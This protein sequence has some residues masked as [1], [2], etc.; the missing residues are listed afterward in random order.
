MQ[1]LFDGSPLE[2]V[3]RKVLHDVDVRVDGERPWDIQVRDPRFYRRALLEGSLGL[4][5]SYMDGWWDCADLEELI[6]R[7][8]S[9]RVDVK[10]RLA[11]FALKM[12]VLAGLTNPQNRRLFQRV[13]R[14]YNLDNDLF[15]AFLGKYKNYSCAHFDGTDDLDVAQAQKMDLICR[16]LDI[17]PGDRVLDIGGGWGEMA[18]HMATRYGAK[19]TSINI[20]DEQIR[21]A[22]EH[23]EGTSVEVV[24]CDYRDLRG[25]FD[26]IA[27]IAMMSHVGHKNHRRLLEIARRCLDGGGVVFIDTVG[28]PVSLTHGNPWIDRYIFP[29]IVFPSLAQIGSA[30]EGLFVIE[31]V[32]NLG[33]SYTKTLRAWNANF[34][35]AWPELA[36]RHDERT[37]R[38]FEFFF[39]TVA[40]YFRASAFQNWH[41][42]MTTQGTPPPSR[43]A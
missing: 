28:A 33:Q 21:F 22:R 13:V 24:K 8:I 25:S 41:I 16:K 37:R 2:A 17:Q 6:H 23:C 43:V 36:A 31:D 14:H 9:K 1:S 11:P 40:G 38:M 32:H 3:T 34:Q 18:K 10:A 19:V 29:G 30:A 4:G 27:I 35:R 5:E 7:F 39:L 42:V 15:C 20:S 26:K 12:Q